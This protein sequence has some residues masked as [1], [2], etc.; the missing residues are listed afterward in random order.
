MKIFIAFGSVFYTRIS[1]SA[2][3]MKDSRTHHGRPH[4]GSRWY[5]TSMDWVPCRRLENKR[6][7]CKLNANVKG[8]RKESAGGFIQREEDS[9]KTE[10]EVEDEL[11]YLVEEQ[12]RAYD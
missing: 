12:A 10:S 11:D 9:M 5:G 8:K 2:I 1:P 7:C 6:N 3:D 4:N